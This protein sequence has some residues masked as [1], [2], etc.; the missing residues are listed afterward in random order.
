MV[1]SRQG[2]DV[3][4]DEGAEE[5]GCGDRCGSMYL[6]MVGWPREAKK[7]SWCEAMGERGQTSSFKKLSTHSLAPTTG[8]AEY[9]W[10][11]RA[12]QCSWEKGGAQEWLHRGECGSG[13]VVR[14][15]NQ[16]SGMMKV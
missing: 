15:C 2:G 16:R 6:P 14:R 4:V 8:R 13:G 7:G 9:H 3:G 1:G 5:C 10:R 11:V 12:L